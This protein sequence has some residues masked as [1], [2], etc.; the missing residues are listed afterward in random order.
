M[1]IA[2]SYA[3]SEQAGDLLGGTGHLFSYPVADGIQEAPCWTFKHNM[4]DRIQQRKPVPVLL[5][6]RPVPPHILPSFHAPL[7]RNASPLPLHQPTHSPV[8]LGTNLCSSGGC[9][10]ICG[11]AMIVQAF[12]SL[13]STNPPYG[14]IVIPLL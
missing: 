8:P 13:G 4:G 12:S 14:V 3:G 5:P 10:F 11:I 6:P 2:G 9:G 1:T 7:P